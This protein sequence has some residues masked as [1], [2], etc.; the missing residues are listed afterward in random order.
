MLEPL[1]L[2]TQQRS[3]NNSVIF[4]KNV[5]AIIKLKNKDNIK[6]TSDFGKYNILNNDTIFNENVIAT[7]LDNKITSKYLDFS[8]ERNTLLISKNVILTTKK[9]ILNSDIIEMNI[10][11]KDTKILMHNNKD[12]VKIKPKT[13]WQ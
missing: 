6:I 7:Y 2:I 10:E 3:P 4:L 1:N 5:Q 12:Q 9:N 8:L 13:R 11:T